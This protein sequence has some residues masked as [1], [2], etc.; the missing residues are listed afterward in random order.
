MPPAT[1]AEITDSHGFT[2]EQTQIREVAYALGSK[3]ADRRFGDLDASHEQWD[4]LSGTGFTGLSLPAEYGG[5]AGILELCLALERTAAGGFPAAKL[6]ISTAIAGCLMTRH[7]SDQQRQRFLPGIADG[8]MRFCF[9]LTEAGS[10]SNAMRMRTTARREGSGYRINGEKTYISALESSDAMLL[11]AQ[12]PDDGGLGVFALELP[13]PEI[14]MTRVGVEVPIFEQQWTLHFDD[15]VLPEEARIGAPGEGLRVLFDGLNPERLTVAAQAVGLGRW[16]LER[17]V[18][19][20]R[21]RVVFEV[22][23]GTHQAV[24]HPLAEAHIGIEGAWQLLLSACRR[25]DSGDQAGSESNMAKIAACDAGFRAADVAMQVF[26]G[27]GYT[28]ESMMLQRFTY[29][30]LLRSIPVAR[31]LALNHVATA[32]LGLPRSY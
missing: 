13:R 31:E 23:I 22:P 25:Y 18:E 12:T 20:A 1:T 14:T 3:Y 27:S 30:R 24:Q 7:G 15:L 6:V 29:L 2:T 21:E 10:G 5:D 11:V 9:A 16:C 4:Q 32:T 28:D 17:A 8:S 19:Y 26:G